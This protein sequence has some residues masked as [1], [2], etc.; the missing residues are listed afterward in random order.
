M[1]K[2]S[3]IVSFAAAFFLFFAFSTTASA[4]TFLNMDSETF[5][6]S[7]F[8]PVIIGAAVIVEALFILAVSDVKRIVNVSFAVLVA[9][10]A[11]ILVPRFAL[12]F[13][14]KEGFYSG[15]FTLNSASVNWLAV[16]AFFAVSLI[17][18]LPIVYFM[19]RAF[20]KK[21]SRLMFSAAAANII[22]FIIII[23]VEILIKNQ[24]IS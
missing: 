13:I 9:N 15:M 1:K 14:R 8:L 6:Y 21:Y 24:M 4:A 17:I 11:S 7:H 12:G 23:V 5:S 3:L 18:E 22:T 10:V 20:T 2:Q 16:I 19:L